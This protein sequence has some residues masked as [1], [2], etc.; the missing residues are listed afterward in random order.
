MVEGTLHCTMYMYVIIIFTIV[1]LQESIVNFS[2]PTDQDVFI[3]SPNFVTLT[4]TDSSECVVVHFDDD[5]VLEET[6]SLTLSISQS[7]QQG[8]QLSPDT[9]IVFITND[10]GVRCVSLLCVV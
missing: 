5:S 1:I 4:S 9:A 3:L 2:S 6:E 8:V 10:D 7:G